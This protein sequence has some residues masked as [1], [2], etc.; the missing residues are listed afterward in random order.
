VR[1]LVASTFVPFREGRS[2]VVARDL[3]NALRARGHD[4]DAVAIPTSPRWDALLEQTL[5][6]RMLDVAGTSDALV[7]IRSPSHALRHHNKRLW[8][9]G[10]HR[11][12]YGL[13]GTPRWD[14]PAGPV[15]AAVRDA[16]TRADDLYLGEA[17]RVFASTVD[18]A[19]R[20]RRFSGIDA[21]LLRAPL[22]H[23]ESFHWEVP[24]DY[25]VLPG[26]IIARARPA[27]AVEAAA[28][29]TSDARV[30]IAG[31]PDHPDVV[32]TLE[33]M[34]A[35]YGLERRVSLMPRRIGDAE[36]AELI[37]RSL[38]VLCTERDA[39]YGHVALEAAH[40]R[41][42]VIACSDSGAPVELVDDARSGLVV[43][44]EP[45]E[46]ARAIDSLR[47]DPSWATALGARATEMLAER[48]LSWDRVVDELLS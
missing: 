40:A 33:A 25:V 45:L 46:L 27:L 17:S 29:L 1:V 24:E 30:V 4:V 48:Q 13:W 31:A 20:L 5:A 3:V 39:G 32:A 41:K 12:G 28:H 43:A 37:A 15:G 19:E 44:P 36:K 7:A 21:G 22:G 9:T 8:F 35:R 10:H 42:A 47:A 2:E 16:V 38:A 26:R 11:T 34:I 23:P 6:M 18:A 14:F